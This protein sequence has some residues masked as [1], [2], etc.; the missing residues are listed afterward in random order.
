MCAA[1][2]SNEMA[3][4]FASD[5][6][7]GNISTL[8]SRSRSMVQGLRFRHCA[9]Y[10]AGNRRRGIMDRAEALRSAAV[11]IDMV[12]QLTVLAVHYCVSARV[13]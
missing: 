11:R 8:L 12:V 7:A 2:W 1:H 5:I 6:G 13:L 10:R 3:R 9:I 4:V